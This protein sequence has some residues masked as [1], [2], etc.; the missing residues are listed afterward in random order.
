MAKRKQDREKGL[1]G[2][3]TLKQELRQGVFRSL[4][5]FYG[6]EQYLL[7]HYRG[8]VKKK[9]VDGPAEDFN[10]HRFT[11]ENFSL[12]ELSLAVEAIPM[13]SERSLVEVVDVDP[14]ARNEGERQALGELFESLPEYCT[15]L[16]SFDAIAWNP[17]KRMK[18]LW[19]PLEKA[20]LLVEFPKQ[21][22]RDLIP[23][24]HRHLAQEHKTMDDRLCR[25]LILQT[26]GSMTIL[27]SELE[28]L[29]RFSDQPVL[30]KYDIDAVV[31]PV[32]EA[33]IFDITKDVG[34]K[35]FDSALLRLRDLLRQDTDPIAITA[36]LG[37]QMRRLY[38]AKLLS[39]NGRGPGEL[40]RLLGTW[41]SNA[42][43]IYAQA[44]D[45]SKS[46]LREAMALCADTDYALKTSSGDGEALVETLLLRLAAVFGG[47]AP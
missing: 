37:Q 31:I 29:M 5:I 23:W 41:D 47:T 30:T 2:Y 21:G 4:Y 46:H 12:E 10:Y 25:Y 28:K 18:K 44:R 40:A 38:G 43:E 34:R 24:I 45:L 8:M 1:A 26:G 35:N 7:A 14:F 33:A 22:E 9:T 13:M 16:W 17:D 32:M 15:L 27:V 3:E 36:V 11:E 6:E 39:E 42:R 20:A 19:E